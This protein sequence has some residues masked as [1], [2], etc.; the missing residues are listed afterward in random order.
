METEAVR[1]SAAEAEQQARPSTCMGMPA[2]GFCARQARQW[3]VF[4]FKRGGF[5]CVPTCGRCDPF[6]KMKYTELRNV[7]AQSGPCTVWEVKRGTF[8]G[9]KTR[10]AVQ[11]WG[12]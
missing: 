3:W 8:G 6:G 1:G 7:V 12:L 9:L 5:V 2:F 11:S 4:F 10:L